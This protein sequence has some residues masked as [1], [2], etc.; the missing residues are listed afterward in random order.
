MA[1]ITIQVHT[2]RSDLYVEIGIISSQGGV[3]VQ[4]TVPCRMYIH[5]YG[6]ADPESGVWV[7]YED[8]V[9]EILDLPSCLAPAEVLL[10]VNYWGTSGAPASMSIANVGSSLRGGPSLESWKRYADSEVDTTEWVRTD[11][12]DGSVENALRHYYQPR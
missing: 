5:G 10:A 1:D 4:H 9:Q 3:S 8:A 2:G 11:Y 7:P 12:C 6:A